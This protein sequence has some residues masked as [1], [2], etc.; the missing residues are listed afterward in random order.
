MGSTGFH[1]V[2]CTKNQAQPGV[3]MLSS[4]CSW[5]MKWSRFPYSSLGDLSEVASAGVASA[6]IWYDAKAF[7]RTVLE[8]AS[9]PSRD[10]QI[11]PG[12]RDKQ[13]SSPVR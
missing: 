7:R 1:S 3:A 12:T 5:S 9:R 2:G 13:L 6:G 10:H 8:V 4:L 11:Q